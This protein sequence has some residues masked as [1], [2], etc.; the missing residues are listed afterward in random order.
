MKRF[1]I[2]LLLFLAGC[3]H[4]V[5]VHDDKELD[6]TGK[7][8]RLAEIEATLKLLKPGDPI[9]LHLYDGTQLNGQ[10]YSLA[11][12]VITLQIGN[13]FRDADL[14]KIRAVYYKSESKNNKAAMLVLI[15]VIMAYIM[16]EFIQNN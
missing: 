2:V 12:G 9:T 13:F 8:T 3:G 4:N 7:Q 16:Y 5:Y 10:F 15:G 6:E 1:L 11:D 14:V